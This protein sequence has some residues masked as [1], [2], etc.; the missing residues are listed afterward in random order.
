MRD[1]RCPHCAASF[2]DENGRYQHAKAKHGKKA[3]REL[4]PAIDH[5]PSLGEELAEAIIA[6]R[7][8]EPVADYLMEM[9]P[10]SFR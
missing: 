10:E 5:E 7:C 8:G 2:T 6:H 3:A 9:F 1:V 4:R